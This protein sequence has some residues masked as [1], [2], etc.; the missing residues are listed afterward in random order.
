MTIKTILIIDDDSSVRH[1]LMKFVELGNY[2]AYGA[3]SALDGLRLFEL[4]QPD[5]I[6]S[7]LV[8]PDIDGYEFCK[9][10]RQTSDVP[11]IMVT[12]YPQG[13]QAT[14]KER[15]GPDIVLA[16]PVTIDQLLSTVEELLRQPRPHPHRRVEFIP[17][18]RLV[19][20]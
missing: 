19:G 18:A 10:I 14:G 4:R 9:L 15:P 5:L 2:K 1:V 12:G 7:D 8:M 16:K 20:G 6:I 3:A 11:I 17:Q 13:R